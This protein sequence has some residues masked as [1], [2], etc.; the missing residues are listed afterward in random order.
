MKRLAEFVISVVL[1]GLLLFALLRHF[2]LR[3]TMESVRQADPNLLIFGFSLMTAA[4]LLRGLRWQ[5]WERSLNYWNSLRLILIGFMGNNILPARLGEVLRAHCAAAKT[6]RDRG[7]TTVLAS[8]AAERILDGLILSLFGIVAIG[9]VHV[10]RRLQWALF[11]VSF[12]FASLTAALVFSFC[13][14]QWILVLISGANRR[15]PGHVTAFVRDKATQLVD[16]LLPLGTLPRMLSAF[17]A[18]AMIWVMEIG[19]CY[20]L[21]LGVWGGMSVRVALLFLAVV[22]FASLLP[23]TMGGIGTIEV[24]APLF[25][26]SCGVPPHLALA[27]VL[28]QHAGQY[29][30]TTITGG[31][32]YLAGGFYRIPLGRPKAATTHRP[33]S[34]AHSSVLEKTRSSLGRLSV[35]R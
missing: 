32:F 30:F 6:D 23:L 21:G 16:G 4:Y 29:S 27:M 10:D 20:C 34:A 28:L 2:D 19:V 5:I 22:N 3:Q 15:F 18:T 14:H 17:A 13:H 25:L 26:I 24:A 8:I 11:L 7:R 12:V 33:V 1:G 35:I 31:I 9:L